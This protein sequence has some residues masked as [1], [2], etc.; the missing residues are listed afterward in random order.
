MVF[1]R[2]V[3]FCF[4]AL[5]LIS[6]GCAGS[7]NPVVDDNVPIPK[8]PA[9]TILSIDTPKAC[10][11]F[12]TNAME[13]NK[14][15]F[16]EEVGECYSLKYDGYEITRRK[17]ELVTGTLP[18]L[19]F[20]K[21][22][23]S[24][25]TSVG[26]ILVGGPSDSVWSGIDSDWFKLL[27]EMSQKFDVIM[28]P[29]YYGTSY[30]SAYPRSGMDAAADEVSLFVRSIQSS[31]IQDITVIGF[32]AGGLVS[33][34]VAQQVGVNALAVNPP[35][36]PI[37][38]SYVSQ[39]KLDPSWSLRPIEE[40]GFLNDGYGYDF[41][42]TRGTRLQMAPWKSWHETYFDD[43]YRRKSILDSPIFKDDNACFS[44]MAGKKDTR[45]GL[46]EAPRY[47]NF[48]HVILVDD[49]D[50]FINEDPEIVAL[51]VQVDTHRKK[52]LAKPAK[53]AG[54]WSE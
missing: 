11:P 25:R 29:A 6:A 51:S 36:I 15:G 22:N 34:G 48:K 28:I 20:Q 39:A 53:R 2:V 26:V 21:G 13:F 23:V 31:G 27:A 42:R 54:T 30:R 17:I 38:E 45:I 35:L 9:Y 12:G 24:K 18:F 49:V 40:R 1:S 7:A 16:P 44:I 32:S 46:P 10:M 19:S 33:E 50:H 41:G 8:T 3:R 14:Y 43:Y 5:S 4:L 47:A 37:E 52:C